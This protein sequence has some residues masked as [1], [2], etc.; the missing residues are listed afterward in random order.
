MLLRPITQEFFEKHRRFF[1]EHH[2]FGWMIDV[3]TTLALCFNCH[4]L[5]TEGLLQAGIRMKRESDPI[6]FARV[7]FRALAVHFRMLSDACWRFANFLEM[8]GSNEKQT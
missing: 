8:G 3:G 2:V 1:E 5:I 4:A 7:V 6:K